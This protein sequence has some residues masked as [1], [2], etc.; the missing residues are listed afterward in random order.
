M[1]YGVDCGDNNIFYFRASNEAEAIQ[2]AQRDFGSSKLV[3]ILPMSL[4]M[5]NF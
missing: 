1:W 4:G 5:F 3:G 2:T